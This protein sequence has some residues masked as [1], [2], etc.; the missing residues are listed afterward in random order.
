M[1]CLDYKITGAVFRTMFVAPAQLLLDSFWERCLPRLSTPIGSSNKVKRLEE[2]KCRYQSPMFLSVYET[3]N[4]HSMVICPSKYMQEN[5]PNLVECFTDN[6]FCENFWTKRGWVK[7]SANNKKSADDI[8]LC[9]VLSNTKEVVFTKF[10][11][12]FA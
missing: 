4:K 1:S 8:K 10:F 3:M 9:D 2:L 12:S 11:P 5:H 7:N 6:P